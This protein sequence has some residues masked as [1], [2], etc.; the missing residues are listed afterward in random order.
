MRKDNIDLIC[1]VAELSGLFEKR[2]NVGGFLQDVVELVAGH[3][4]SDVC[5]IYLY[6]EIGDELVLRATRGLNSESV[7][8]VRLSLG[9]GL[10][11]LSL[12]QLRPIR[13]G[14]V[15]EN[16]D[17]KVI[18]EVQEEGYRSFL[19]VPIRRGLTRIGV[20]SLQHRKAGY[21]DH[22]DTKALKAIASQ[23]AATLENASLLMDIHSSHSQSVAEAYS[24]PG[25]TISGI[26]AGA[27]V[28]IGEAVHLDSRETKE[29]AELPRLSSTEEEVTRFQTA[30]ER[31]R[32]QLEQLQRETE[33]RFSDVA[34]LIFSSHLL[35]LR[36]DEFSG[37]MVDAVR[38]GV[39]AAEA[40]HMVV[41]RYEKLFT[42]MHNARLQ[43]KVQ[44]VKDLGR[45]IIRNLFDSGHDDGDYSE[46]VVIANEIYPSELVK[47]AVQHVEAIVI[48]GTTVTSHISILAR[49]LGLPVVATRNTRVFS[50]DE[51]ETL[52][53]DGNNGTVHLNPADDVLQQYRGLRDEEAHELETDPDIPE[54]TRTHC[55]ERVRIMANVNL[56][57]DLRFARRNKAEG[58]GLYRSEFPFI[59]RN[60][61]PSEEEQRAI[62][63]KIIEQMNGEEIVL[64]TLDIGGDKLVA[65][66][67]S[68]VEANPFLGQRGIRFSLAHPDIFTDQLRGMLRAGIDADLSIMF[69]MISGVDE[70]HRARD[71]VNQCV[72]ELRGEGV[73]FNENPRIGAMIELPSAIEIA[74]EL[75]SH[76][77]FLCVGTN[78]LV[79]Y[80][81]GVDRTNELVSELYI[82]HHPA[83]LRS[84]A[85]LAEA[86]HEP[87]TRLSI[88]GEA[89]ADPALIP[90][91][92]GIGVR[93]LSVEPRRIP[94][95]K[96]QVERVSIDEA[97][98][99]A[100]AMLSISTMQEMQDY[101]EETLGVTVFPGPVNNA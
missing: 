48:G 14:Q 45:R 73:E 19:A 94:D 36:D 82:S 66:E 96:R 41:G 60:D 55:G 46:Q 51:H 24:D 34:S 8:K 81:L 35:M 29:L 78:D 99:I 50:V 63:R 74:S 13:E 85:R 26:S 32:T 58:V 56:I 52:V 21:F 90:F 1:S 31:S 93:S 39:N 37:H 53:V 76:A 91:F 100:G 17:F 9:E 27:G 40:V 67:D 61:F 28:G 62:Y 43:E 68:E 101:I 10:T 54:R 69:P 16:P 92:L 79:M 98:R 44:D 72:E 65:Y 3:M 42:E 95:V 20:I 5:S 75:D 80:F 89:A 12:K 30:I 7:G 87:E 15:E 88:C 70:F 97:T 84:L 4:M 22:H 6:D 23:L 2:S 83:I 25:D 49:S 33:S 71:T 18:P 86:M 38:D 64:R 77:D 57:N 47:L 11:G 59:V